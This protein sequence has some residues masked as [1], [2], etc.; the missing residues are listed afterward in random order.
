MSIVKRFAVV[1][2][3]VVADTGES[4][5]KIFAR[6]HPL[7][8]WPYIFYA[9]LSMNGL[10]FN[11]ILYTHGVGSIT[12]T[13]WHIMIAITITLVVYEMTRAST[14]QNE[15]MIKRNLHNGL[16][17]LYVVT[18]VASWFQE[19]IFVTTEFIILTYISL[20]ETTGG[21]IINGMNRKR[22]IGMSTSSAI[23]E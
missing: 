23:T 1:V 16:L 2:K 11:Q 5:F 20:L 9:I 3:D 18:F 21:N 6:F 7:L 12:V 10:D 19:Q 15:M 4:I 22:D 14:T 13:P 17:V 8:I